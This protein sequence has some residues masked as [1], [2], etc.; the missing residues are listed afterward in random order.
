MTVSLDLVFALLNLKLIAEIIWKKAS[1]QAF[2]KSKSSNWH[3]LDMKKKSTSR[4]TY[5]IRLPVGNPTFLFICVW[6]CLP[7]RTNP[8]SFLILPVETRCCKHRMILDLR[9]PPPLLP[10]H[11]QHTLT[12]AHC[13]S[14]SLKTCTRFVV[15]C[16]WVIS[17]AQLCV[18]HKPE[19]FSLACMLIA[20]G[21]LLHAVLL[22][23]PPMV[24]RRC[25]HLHFNKAC[26]YL[27][28]CDVPLHHYKKNAVI[29]EVS[30]ETWLMSLTLLDIFSS[31]LKGVIM[32]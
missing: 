8:Q 6:C 23:R 19:I 20:C 12:N 17:W 13:Y 15:W 28:A 24:R 30:K 27:L 4:G 11:H 21:A 3:K 22:T 1:K 2:K 5:S 10:C 7:V 32:H 14:Y 16:T 25:I 31:V 29:T 18:M 9:S 26:H